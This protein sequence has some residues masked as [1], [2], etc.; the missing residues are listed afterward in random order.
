MIAY[1]VTTPKKW[2]RCVSTGS[3][4]APV[5]WWSTEEKARKWMRKTGRTMLVTF[6]AP[7]R[8][9]PLPVRGRAA[10]WSDDSVSVQGCSVEAGL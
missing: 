1:H 3:I 10:Y 6:E 2:A 7:E 9:Y 8:R 5:R 4:L